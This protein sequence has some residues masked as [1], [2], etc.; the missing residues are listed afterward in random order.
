VE[1]TALFK[2]S[3]RIFYRGDFWVQKHSAELKDAKA[4]TINKK[5]LT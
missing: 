1:K 4:W 2:V 3:G 5:V